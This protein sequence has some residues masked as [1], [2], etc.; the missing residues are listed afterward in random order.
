[1]FSEAKPRKT[2]QLRG[3]HF[4]YFTRQM[5][6]II[7]LSSSLFFSSCLHLI[8]LTASRRELG[9]F[10]YSSWLRDVNHFKSSRRRFSVSCK[11]SE[12]KQLLRLQKTPTKQMD[13]KS[14]L[15]IFCGGYQLHSVSLV[16]CKE[17]ERLLVSAR[18]QEPT[19]RCTKC[20]IFADNRLFYCTE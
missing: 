20:K 3:Y 5:E 1:M 19:S 9:I 17:L 12:M 4:C 7:L 16:T 18:I 14:W 13:Q 8:S 11:T 6:I 15:K 2:E 10:C